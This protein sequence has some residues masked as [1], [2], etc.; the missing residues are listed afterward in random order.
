MSSLLGVRLTLL[1]G[2]TVAR[3][4]PLTFLDSLS[5]VEVEHS[6]EQRSGFQLTFRVGRRGVLDLLD[7]P[8]LRSPLLAPFNRVILIVTFNVRP[9]VLM[10]G[11]ITHV[12]LSPG[13]ESGTGTLT[14]TGED[15]SAMM[16]LEERAVEHPAL[17]DPAIV[18]K[19]LARYARYG[20]VPVIVP[21][22]VSE[23]PLPIERIP[24]QVGTDRDYLELLA[25]RHGHVF[26]LTAGPAPFTN[27]AYWGPPRRLGLP[28]RAL[29]VNFGADTNVTSLSFRHDALKPAF[30]DGDIQDARF[31]RKFPVKT[32]VAQRVPP[33]S[34]RP[35]W[36]AHRAKTRTVRLRACTPSLSAAYGRAQAFTDAS[37]D[38]TLTATGELD[39]ARYGEVLR[40]RELVGL[41]GAGFAHDGLYY[42]KAV[43][44]RLGRGSYTQSF[45]LTRDGLGSTVPAVRP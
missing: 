20:L 19:L 43:T 39:A 44:H 10:D 2:P 35:T 34:V 15:V 18:A 24:V 23:P 1:L 5:G 13:D 30:V 27:T 40:A 6:D 45:T 36:L 9:R 21:P 25:E 38:S 28:Q 12:E 26:Y 31:N 32:F 22:K 7:Y 42:V 37:T 29:S 11:V 16:D 4:A 17:P 3:P 33:L 41:R 8:Q 14:V